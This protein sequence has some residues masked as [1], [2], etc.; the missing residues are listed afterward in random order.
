VL[1]SSEIAMRRIVEGRLPFERALKERI[2]A[3]DADGSRFDKLMG[4]W[5]KAYPKVGFSRF[6]CA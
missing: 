5:S 4:A 2:V 6:V 1:V 3:L